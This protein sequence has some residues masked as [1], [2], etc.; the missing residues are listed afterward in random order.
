MRRNFRESLFRSQGVHFRES[1]VLFESGPWSCRTYRI[2]SNTDGRET[3]GDRM[4]ISE[5]RQE[6][7]SFVKATFR[8]ECPNEQILWRF[9]WPR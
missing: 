1:I 4:Q 7:V 5:S 8:F 6:N 3:R 2:E 9:Q